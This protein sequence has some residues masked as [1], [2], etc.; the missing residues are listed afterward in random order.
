WMLT[1]RIVAIPAYALRG[2]DPAGSN[3][4]TDLTVQASSKGQV[5]WQ[6]VVSKVLTMEA[7][8]PAGV[9]PSFCIALIPLKRSHRMPQLRFSVNAPKPGSLVSILSFPLSRA[10]LT[11]SL[12][13]L[14]SQNEMSL[15]YDADSQPGSGGA[16]LFDERWNV[17]GMH[18]TSSP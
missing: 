15:E 3:L 12:G 8:D 5:A 7:G 17:V 13:K 11:L 1:P 16:P 2:A 14:M 18:M 4:R 10:R 9:D 6:E